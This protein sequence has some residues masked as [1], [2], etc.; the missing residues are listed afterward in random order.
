M[1]I[2]SGNLKMKKQNNNLKHR[3]QHNADAAY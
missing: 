3:A 1:I 2:Q